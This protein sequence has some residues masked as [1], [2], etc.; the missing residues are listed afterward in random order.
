MKHLRLR[1]DVHGHVL[2][3]LKPQRS[4][5]TLLGIALLLLNGLYNI[6]ELELAALYLLDSSKVLLALTQTGARLSIHTQ[7]NH[8]CSRLILIFHLF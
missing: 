4:L 6:L 7:M 2:A 1:T 8:S 3:C 5:L